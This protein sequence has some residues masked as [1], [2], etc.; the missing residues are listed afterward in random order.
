[1]F[2]ASGDKEKE[3]K[4]ILLMQNVL[5]L[6]DFFQL[7]SLQKLCID[8]HIIQYLNKENIVIFIKDAFAKLLSSQQQAT[9]EI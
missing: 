2:W 1:M 9:D 3:G 8:K 4:D 5:W 7:H 6:A